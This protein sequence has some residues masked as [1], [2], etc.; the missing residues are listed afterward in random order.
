MPN[1]CENDLWVYGPKK[2]LERLRQFMKGDDGNLDYNKFIPY[3]RK[4]DD[5][6]EKATIKCVREIEPET[7]D[8]TDDEVRVYVR[9]SGRSLKEL[10]GWRNEGYNSGGCDWCIKN[11]GTKW[12]ASNTTVV[13]RARSL[14]VMFTSPWSPPSPV[15]KKMGKMFPTLRFIHKYY[16]QGMAFRGVVEIK[17]GH[18]I[19]DESTEYHGHRG[20]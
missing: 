14:F 3:P 13:T 1:W 10:A 17:R 4:F 18:V 7:K 2:E 19:R 6:T 5:I 12:N 11:W 20:G 16:E 15:I 9:I 8:M